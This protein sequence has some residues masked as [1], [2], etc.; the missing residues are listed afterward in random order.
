M[1][2]RTG[3]AHRPDHRGV[4]IARTDR[5]HHS[6]RPS[7]SRTTRPRL[8]PRRQ[9]RLDYLEET[10]IEPAGTPGL[11]FALTEYAALL[12]QTLA[13]LNAEQRLEAGIAQRL[14]EADAADDDE[15][16]DGHDD[17]RR[18]AMTAGQREGRRDHERRAR[19]ASLR[20]SWP[21]P[22]DPLIHRG[23]DRARTASPRSDD[24]LAGIL[25]TA[26]PSRASAGR[27]RSR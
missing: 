26:G 20:V 10:A 24:G 12:T 18:R 16:D 13:P 1:T 3:P 8:D 14:A 4:A 15:R 9:A 11:L 23:S 22:P 2:T 25:R 17:K 6:H 21:Y 7:T 5:R 27:R 19:P